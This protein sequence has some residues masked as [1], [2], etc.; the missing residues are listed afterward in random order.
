MFE[1]S[2]DLTCIAPLHGGSLVVLGSNHD[3]PAM[4]QYLIHW[5]TAAPKC[6]SEHDLPDRVIV[7]CPKLTSQLKINKKAPNEKRDASVD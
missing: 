7:A 3:M 2:T 1:L 6:F 4:I 5:A